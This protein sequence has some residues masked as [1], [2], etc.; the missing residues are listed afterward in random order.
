MPHRPGVAGQLPSSVVRECPLGTGSDSPIGHATGTSF[1]PH[2]QL[3]RSG[4]FH[5][6][7]HA[8][9]SVLVRYFR[10]SVAYRE[11]PLDLMASGP[12]V[13]RLATI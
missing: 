6:A 1:G 10:L 13:A 8:N 11:C 2:D 9:T 12:S 3:G 4:I 5:L 7:R